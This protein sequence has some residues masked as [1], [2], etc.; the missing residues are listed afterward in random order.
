[1]SKPPKIDKSRVPEVKEEDIEEKFIRGWGPGGQSIN[2]TSSAVYLRHIPTGITVKCQKHRA[3][4]QNRKE[5]RLLL[6]VKWDEVLNGEDS[7]V[8]QQKR[9]L[10]AKSVKR[11]SKAKKRR[12]L[13]AEWKQSLRND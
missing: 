4:H 2:K 12:Q 9:L 6:Q 11:M 8:A 5:A 3:Q 13:Q 7:V 10:E 1:S